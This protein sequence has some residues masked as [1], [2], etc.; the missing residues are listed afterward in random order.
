MLCSGNVHN[1]NWTVPWLDIFG[2][3]PGYGIYVSFMFP[4]SVSQLLAKLKYIFVSYGSKLALVYHCVQF[5][6]L[7]MLAIHFNIL[8]PDSPKLRLVGHILSL[9]KIVLCCCYGKI[10]ARYLADTGIGAGFILVTMIVRTGLYR[11]GRGGF[12]VTKTITDNYWLTI[13]RRNDGSL[14]NFF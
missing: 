14:D 5:R 7:P 6:A 8:W 12:L 2:L 11:P 3:P 1:N 10:L 4:L 9:S 13:M